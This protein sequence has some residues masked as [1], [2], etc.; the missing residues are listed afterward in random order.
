EAPV[1]V[2][3]MSSRNSF[4]EDHRLFAGFLA[5]NRSAIVS[6]LHGHDLILVLGAP[7]FTYHV[8]GAGPVIP[9]GAQLVQL[10]DDPAAAAWAQVGTAIVTSLKSGITELLA[11]V[12]AVARTRRMA[13]PRPA[14]LSGT[15][16]TD[17]Y[18]LQ[19]IAAL[20]PADSIIVEEAPSSR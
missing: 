17:A 10:V 16:L 5:A 6:S 4:P 19:Q 1:W 9:A 13:V 12:P 7:A 15:P 14:R 20:R 18:V 11:A 3:P 2:S 8:E